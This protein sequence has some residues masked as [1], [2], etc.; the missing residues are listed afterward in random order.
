MLTLDQQLLNR[1]HCPCNSR[2]IGASVLVRSVEDVDINFLFISPN[3]V[4]S[5]HLPGFTS[6]GQ[7]GDQRTLEEIVWPQ[8]AESWRGY[9]FVYYQPRLKCLFFFLLV[10]FLISF[11]FLCPPFSQAR[12]KSRNM[13]TPKL[14]LVKQRSICRV[15]SR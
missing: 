10:S 11:P 8:Q 14:R 3:N 6:F 5:P 2:T 12:K 15:A 13:S 7:K 4:F 9:E 1:R